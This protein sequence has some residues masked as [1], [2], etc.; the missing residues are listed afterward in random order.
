MEPLSP[1]SR[2]KF[3]DLPKEVQAFLV[4]ESLLA[5]HVVITEKE[6]GVRLRYINAELAPLALAIYKKS[7]ATNNGAPFNSDYPGICSSSPAPHPSTN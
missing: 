4:L 7:K 1:L 5:T 3:V 6:L 2:L